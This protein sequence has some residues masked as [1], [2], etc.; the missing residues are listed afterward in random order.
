MNKKKL[1]S[2]VLA[3]VLL[4]TGVAATYAYFT[5]T[6][7]QTNIITMGNVEID[8]AEPKYELANPD[9][10]VRDITPG[11]VIE[12]DPTITLAA[13]SN[14]A[15]VRAKIEVDGK[16]TTLVG[17]HVDELI[18]GINFMDGWVLGEDGY[19]YY[20]TA[21]TQENK[22]VLVFDKVTIPESWGNETN[23]MKFE[24]NVTA[25]AIQAENFTPKT[26]NDGNIINW[27][28]SKGEAVT[29]ENFKV[30]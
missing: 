6:K 17:N 13:T 24:I 15:Y 7:S 26:T 3:L 4:V 23:G 11:K 21:L 14:T 9:F 2:A 5:D 10:T 25:E 20:N 30:N 29:V 28:N 1:I 16:I 12:K 8:L 27:L 22:T 18:E 19:Y